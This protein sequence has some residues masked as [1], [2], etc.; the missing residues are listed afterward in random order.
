MTYSSY[1]LLVD[2]GE[3]F[4]RAFRR[5]V[6]RSYKRAAR[7][8]ARLEAFPDD[9]EGCGVFL[10]GS[11]KRELYVVGAI[12]GAA[13]VALVDHGARTIKP[14]RLLEPDDEAGDREGIVRW[15]EEYLGI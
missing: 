1:R 5:F 6:E 7:L 10:R 8:L 3:D 2:E 11:G 14:V 9:P 12:D 13:L 15:A 4:D